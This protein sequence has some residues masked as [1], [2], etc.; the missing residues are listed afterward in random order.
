MTTVLLPLGFD[1]DPALPQGVRAVRYDVRAPVPA[2]HADADALVVWLNTPAQLA[3]CARR[4]GRLRWVQTLAA[5]PDAVLGAGFGPDVVVTNGR[6]LHD[7]P[8]AEHTL[9]LLLAGARRVPDLVQAQHE[10][11]WARELGGAQQLDP[12]GSFRTLDGAHVLIWG[13]GSIAAR[14]APVLAALGA[15]VTG[16]ARTA[17]ERAGFRVVASADIT[18]ELPATD[19]L[20]GLLPA[21]PETRHAI[22]A[23]V[24]GLLPPTAWVVN[25][26]RGSTLDEDALLGALRADRLAGAALDVFETEPLPPDS[27]LWDSPRILISPHAAGGRPQGASELIAH[28]L[29]AFL[30]GTPLHNVVER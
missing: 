15:H 7:G 30:S 6:G 1:L 5:G 21:T 2:E 18:A 12:P 28:N 4:L 25:V 29:V 13:F 17:G 10:H 26:G 3:D 16:V 9:A 8:V 24:L 20:V 11:R 22:G 19:V 23:E 14:L 27:P